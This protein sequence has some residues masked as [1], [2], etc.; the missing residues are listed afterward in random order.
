[1]GL[2]VYPT[3]RRESMRIF[4][5]G[6]MQ[7]SHRGKDINDQNYRQT[8]SQMI[9]A[10]H[11]T[12]EIVDPWALFLNSIDYD[13]DRACQVLYEMAEEAARADAVLAYLPEAS[14]GTALEIVRA[15]D[16][17]TPVI[18][19]SPLTEN[20]F[21]RCFSQR[22]FSSLEAFGDWVKASGLATIVNSKQEESATSTAAV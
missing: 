6:V 13:D 11:P 18:C 10:Q 7:G 12:A 17:S 4:I 20:W 3:R 19:I 2:D 9:K 8:I 21:I 14:M 16:A 5:G 22:V 15:C 1:M